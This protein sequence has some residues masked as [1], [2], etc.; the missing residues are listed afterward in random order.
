ME[1]ER[2]RGITIQSAAIT[3]FWKKHRINL[4]DT[5]GHVD[6]TLEVCH[7]MKFNLPCSVLFLYQCKMRRN[8]KLKLSLN[9]MEEFRNINLYKVRET[10]F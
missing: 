5:P 1:L 7:W 3:L 4:I 10:I 9:F 8:R 2:E 6:F